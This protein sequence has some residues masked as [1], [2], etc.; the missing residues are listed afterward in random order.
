MKKIMRL[1]MI[2]AVLTL[3]LFGCGG[4]G[5]GDTTTTTPP[6]GGGGGGDTAGTV[7]SVGT[8]YSGTFVGSTTL[9]KPPYSNKWRMNISSTG[10]VTGHT[11]NYN[12]GGGFF[13]GT[14]SSSTGALTVQ[15]LGGGGSPTNGDIMLT[16]TVDAATGNVSG[17]WVLQT[18]TARTGTFTGTKETIPAN[19]FTFKT[20]GTVYDSYKNLTWLK[21]ANCYGALSLANATASVSALHSGQCGLTDSSLAGSWRLPTTAEMVS[22]LDDGFISDSLLTLGFTNVQS[23]NN[24]YWSSDVF[25]SNIN[26]EWSVNLLNGNIEHINIANTSYV[27]PVRTGP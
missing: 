6:A 18:N 26:D 25:Y 22:Y 4:G 16:G 3:P 7:G 8:V 24:N 23:S 17:T 9:E 5:G 15:V 20:N 1:I 2:C 14:F 19:R 11:D 21:D 27:W 10:T 13:N 12:S